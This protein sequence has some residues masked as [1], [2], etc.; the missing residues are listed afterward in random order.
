MSQPSSPA[1]Q[2]I[3]TVF[4]ASGFI[5][6]NIVRELAKRCVRVNAVCLDVEHA[7]FL[8]P[9]GV[10]GQVTPMRADVTDP[11]AIARTVTGASAVINLVGILHSS[12]RN[13][14]D[15]IQATAPGL[16]A[17]AAKQAGATKM[18]HISA[19]GADSESGA[20]YAR[21]KAQGE[22]AV[23]GAFPQAT[24]LRPSIVFG[25]NDAFFNRFASMAMVS[26]FLPLIGGGMTKF[27]PVYV[28]DVA[29]AAMAA[30][31][32]PEA[33][34]RTYELG[35]PTVFTFREL[36]ELTMKV[37][38]RKRMLVEIPF[39]AAKIQAAVL[40]LLPSPPLT[41]D[42]VELLKTDN[43]VAPGARTL[44]EL[45]IEA[46]AVDAILPTYLEKFRPG[47]RYNSDRIPA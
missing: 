23:R 22:E 13:T 2:Q 27:Q 19:I 37:M 38:R 1:N 28:D 5:G 20:T 6:R 33:A 16:I 21:T 31:D 10:V 24:I 32:L 41:R 45:G 11:D 44:A 15:A 47:G 14:F 25:P 3:V 12:G 30:L 17:R 43:V 7:K 35:G 29:D 39:W 9:I 4:G 46:T 26:P 42:Q 8:K 36:M 40:E 34:G 18:V